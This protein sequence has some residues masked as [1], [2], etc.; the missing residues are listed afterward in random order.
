[1]TK[2]M[3]CRY[4]NKMKTKFVKNSEKYNVVDMCV[5]CYNTKWR[6]FN[7][8]RTTN[9]YKQYVLNKKKESVKVLDAVLKDM[10]YNFNTK[11]LHLNSDINNK[12]IEKQKN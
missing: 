8:D 9:S 1:M 3:L 5:N 2:K 11:S 6:K 10:G 7:K 12:K 4:C